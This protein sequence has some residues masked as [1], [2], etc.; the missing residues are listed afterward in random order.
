MQGQ[1][2][3]YKRIHP[4]LKPIAK[5]MWAIN[6][7]F[8][9]QRLIAINRMQGLLNR[10]RGLRR[11]LNWTYAERSDGSPLQLLVLKPKPFNR[12]SNQLDRGQ[13][14]LLVLWFH[15]GGYAIGRPEKSRPMARLLASVSPCVFIAP[16]YRLSPEAPYPAALEDAYLALTWAQAQAETLGI[17]PNRI[18][19]GGES[20]GGGLCAAL[21]LYARDRGNKG[22]ILQM[23]L[24]PMLDDRM[25]TASSQGNEDPIWNSSSNAIAWRLYLG[26]YWGHDAV[27]YYAAPARALD[28]SGLPPLI[29]FIGDLEPF[30][31][32]SIDYFERLRAAGVSVEYLI[33]KGAYHGFD[34]V[35]KKSKPAQEALVFLL[36]AFQRAMMED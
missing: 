4:D 19:V 34:Q 3:F 7:T 13:G 5:V 1:K 32:E 15:G 17:D 18:V 28:L 16:Q 33:V 31:D 21:C 35:A 29:A 36:G 26:P 23:P 10:L 12:P 9:E 11:S 14:L 6:P 8:T 2:D 20:A 24:Y 30:C 22:I 27:P 25:Q